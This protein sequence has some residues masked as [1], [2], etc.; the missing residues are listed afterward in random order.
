KFVLTF[1]FVLFIQIFSAQVTITIPTGNPP[2][3]T[4]SV[5]NVE[6][7]KPLGTY[8]GY[9]RTAFIYRHSELGMYGQINAIAIYCDS[10]NH[11]GNVPLNIY[12]RETSDSAFTSLSTVANEESGATLVY[13]GTIPSTSFVKNQ[14]VNILFNTPFTHATSKPVEF[15]FETNATGS[16]NESVSGK[17]FTH[18]T[19]TSSYYTSQYWNNDN[20]APTS[21]GIASFSRP[22]AQIT[23]TAISVCSGMPNAGTIL[24][25]SDTLCL[26]E[27]FVLSLQGNTSAT[28]LS[29]QWQKSADGLTFF[30]ISQADS[31]TLLQTLH[32]TVWYRCAITCTGQT[33][34]STIKQI[35]LRDFM[36]CYC[37]NL[38]GDCSSNTAI[39]S[40]A[41]ENTTLANG[42]TGC[43]VNSYKLYPENGNTTAI[44]DQGSSYTLDTRFNGNVGA[45]F[46]I[47]YN[48]NGILENAEWTQICTHSPSI[49]DTATVGGVLTTQVDSVFKTT[50]TVP[51]N[52][53]IGHTLLRVR[54]RASGNPNDSSTV[55]T[56]F[57]SGETEDYYV[58]IS[59]PAGIKQIEN[60]ANQV[61]VY[62]NPAVNQLNVIANFNRNENIITSIYAINGSLVSQKENRYMGEPLTMDVSGLDAGIYFLKIST[63]EYTSTKKIIISK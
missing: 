25:T 61:S 46:W 27:N 18:Y 7:R 33:A 5:T 13:S 6:H 60:G 48:Q 40:V 32:D 50:F 57:G 51:L 35:I 1:A 21:N 39:D 59:Y 24:S 41:I 42:L 23:M 34:Y 45:S 20:T 4:V 2:T 58:Y 47:D 55:C 12:V 53:Q 36:K 22:N 44:L 17:F 19:A 56:T 16:G 49:Y 30:N 54:S 9:E 15:I 52:A 62:P 38:G 37:S 28:G 31:T 8:F 43:S 26:N 63:P 3:N 14:W 29:Y 11:P 10:V